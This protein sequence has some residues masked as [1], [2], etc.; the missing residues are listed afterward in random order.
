MKTQD[1]LHNVVLVDALH[2]IGSDGRDYYIDGH[3]DLYAPPEALEQA[4]TRDSWLDAV[5]VASLVTGDYERIRDLNAWSDSN[6][7]VHAD[8]VAQMN[9][10]VLNEAP[11]YLTGASLLSGDL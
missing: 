6:T 8:L 1:M 11:K 2:L 10:E 4:E 3:V 9:R 5:Y 7:A